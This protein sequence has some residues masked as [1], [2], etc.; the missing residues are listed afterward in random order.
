VPARRTITRLRELDDVSGVPGAGQVPIWNGS[1]FEY[2]GLTDLGDDAFFEDRRSSDVSTVPRVLVR[3][4]FTTPT[5][6][7]VY[8]YFAYARAGT[9]TKI[10]F[11]TGSVAGAS[12]SDFRLGVWAED[13]TPLVA[14]ANHAA[15]V[16]AISTLYT[17]DLL[18]PVTLARRQK[19][20]L[21]HAGV[22]T[23]NYRLRGLFYGLGAIGGLSPKLSNS[24]GGWAG[25]ALPSLALGGTSVSFTVWMELVP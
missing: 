24:T 2:G 12:V 20:W 13:G 23:T 8:G 16:T 14:T 4:E 19:I 3:D 18:A 15:T 9:F 21:G 11:A 10:R 25:G 22:A 6:G 17:L 7:I 1:A 5:S